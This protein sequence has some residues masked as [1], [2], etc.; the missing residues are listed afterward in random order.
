MSQYRFSSS[1]W[2]LHLAFI[3][4]NLQTRNKAKTLVRVT[5]ELEV[6]FKVLVLQVVWVLLSAEEFSFQEFL[7][8]RELGCFARGSGEGVPPSWN[9]RV[10]SL[11][12]FYAWCMSLN[13]NVHWQSAVVERGCR[14][15]WG[16]LGRMEQLNWPLCRT[17]SELWT[18]YEQQQGAMIGTEVWHLTLLVG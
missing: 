17:M 6:L 14:P 15:G 8:Y 10:E 16:F 4:S 11:Q 18:W 3:Q 9:S 1:Y 12:P 5:F 13:A 2:H 7:E